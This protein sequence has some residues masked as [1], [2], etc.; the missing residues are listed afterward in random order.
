MLLEGVLFYNEPRTAQTSFV[1]HSALTS[2]SQVE[3]YTTNKEVHN[4]VR[5]TLADTK[6]TKEY[7]C[8]WNFWTT[9]RRRREWAHSQY[10]SVQYSLFT[11]A[12]RTS[13]AW[14]KGQHGSR[15]H[16]L[17]FIIVRLKR[18]CHL[19]LH[20]SHPFVVLSPAL[21]HEH[22]IFLIRSSFNDTR[23]RSTNGTT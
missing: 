22:F 3:C 14:L 10:T 1:S 18:I 21:Y 5:G 17:H 8:I 4:L 11:S 20:M 16:G 9:W 7:A 2:G 15:N 6:D 23:T 13:R 12:E 19:V